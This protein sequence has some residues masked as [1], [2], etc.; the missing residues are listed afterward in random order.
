MEIERV[1]ETQEDTREADTE[2]KDSHARRNKKVKIAS[3]DHCKDKE[4]LQRETEDQSRRRKTYT[5]MIIGFPSYVIM[6]DGPSQNDGD[7]S[8]DDI[9]EEDD[10]GPRINLGMT[11][12]EKKKAREPWK[13]SA[14]FKLVGRQ[15]NFHVLYQ[16]IQMLWQLTTPFLLIDL[17]KDVYM[18]KLSNK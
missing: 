9:V 12:E 13:H 15:I 18:V 14:I 3:G 8:D 10:D 16:Q 11:K 2:E 7:L 1:D 17:T 4:D 6:E 5:D